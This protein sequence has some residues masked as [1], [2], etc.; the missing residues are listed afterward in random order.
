M[1]AL[2]AASLALVS[3]PAA[4]DAAGPCS[5]PD[6]SGLVVCT[7]DGNAGSAP[8]TYILVIP[9]GSPEFTVEVFG[10]AG[11]GTG[12]GLPFGLGA[13]VEAQYMAP[14][15]R[16]LVAVAAAAPASAPAAPVVAA[17]ADTGAAAAAA[18]AA[19]A[20]QVPQVW[21]IQTQRVAAV[22]AAAPAM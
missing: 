9:A 5:S 4:A 7:F 1:V 10:A 14:P 2:V 12:S 18:R 8:G 19:G 11:G 20:T 6:S 21:V 3:V 13:E 15:G 16:Q 17:A 22:A